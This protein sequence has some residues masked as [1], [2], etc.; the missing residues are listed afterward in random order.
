MIEVALAMGIIG[1]IYAWERWRV[2]RIRA[3]AELERQR[4][5]ELFGDL[6]KCVE[7]FHDDQQD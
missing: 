1:A 4:T 2:R 6:R 5:R 7:H 3:E